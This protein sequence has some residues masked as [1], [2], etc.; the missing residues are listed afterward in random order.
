MTLRANR[1]RKLMKYDDNNYFT[2]DQ[3]YRDE[4]DMQ[5]VHIYHTSSYFIQSNNLE[6][7]TKNDALN[8]KESSKI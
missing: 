7:S 2:K 6:D 4:T 5:G 3:P 1:E 8:P